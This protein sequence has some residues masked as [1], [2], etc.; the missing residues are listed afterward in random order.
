[1]PNT[2]ADYLI[3]AQSDRDDLADN[4]VAQGVPASHSETITEL[5]PKVLDIQTG[6]GFDGV[7]IIPVQSMAEAMPTTVTIS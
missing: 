6:G 4:L 7:G 1:M 5:V 3:Q 2:T